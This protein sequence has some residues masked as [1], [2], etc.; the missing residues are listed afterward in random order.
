[1]LKSPFDNRA[2]C[3]LRRGNFDAC[4]VDAYVEVVNAVDLT[5]AIHAFEVVSLT[6]RMVRFCTVECNVSRS[7]PYRH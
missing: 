3:F 2:R 1:M 6:K 7:D 4:C 5:L